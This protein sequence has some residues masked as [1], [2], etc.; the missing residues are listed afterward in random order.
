MEE[1]EQTNPVSEPTH[2]RQTNTWGTKIV[3]IF[4]VCLGLYFLL[5]EYNLLDNTL[6]KNIIK[7]WPLIFVYIGLDRLTANKPRLKPVILVLL[8]AIAVFF[9]LLQSDGYIPFMR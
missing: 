8:V 9:V 5:R 1:Q 2:V 6:V 3:P 4:L 7:L